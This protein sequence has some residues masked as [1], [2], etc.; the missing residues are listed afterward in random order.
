MNANITADDIIS[1]DE[2]GQQFPSTGTT[3]GCVRDCNTVVCTVNGTPYT[4]T[5]ESDGTFSIDVPGSELAADP[6]LT[7]EASVTTSTGNVNGEATATDTE[8]YTVQTDLVTASISLNANITADDIISA[9]ELG[10][11]IPITG[12]TGGDVPARRTV[13]LTVNGTP[14]TGTVESDGTFSIDVPGSELAADPGLT[15]EASVTTRTGNVNGEATATDTEGYTVQ[16]D[17]ATASITLDE[18]ITADDIISADEL[19]QQIPTPALPG[20]LPI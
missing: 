12:T 20:A 18:N 8:G 19:G 14:Y 7:V 9:D 4:G 1:A 15:V 11:Q 17:L 3:G 2:L 13:T 5:V 16:T 10:Q 6:G